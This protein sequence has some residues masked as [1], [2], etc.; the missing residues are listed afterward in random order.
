MEPIVKQYM[1]KSLLGRT[2]VILIT[3]LAIVQLISAIVF[4]DTHWG[5]IMDRLAQG[6]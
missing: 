6:V 5:K 2:M 1:P 3:P 4:Y